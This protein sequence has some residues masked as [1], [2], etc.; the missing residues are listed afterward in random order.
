MESDPEANQMVSYKSLG[1]IPD[2]LPI[3]PA[4]CSSSESTLDLCSPLGQCLVMA[5]KGDVAVVVKTNGIPFWLVGAPPILEPISVGIGMFTGG[6][7]F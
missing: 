6:T 5:P 1:S 4:S 2:S 3:A 7:G